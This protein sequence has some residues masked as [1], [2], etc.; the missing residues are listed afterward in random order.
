MGLRGVILFSYLIDF[1][2]GFGLDVI[3]VFDVL[4]F[5]GYD[6]V[7][8]FGKGVVIKILD[9]MIIC[10]YCMINYLKKVVIDK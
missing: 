3:I 7:I 8:C 5:N 4:G 6:V 1:D 9:G 10:D 2:F